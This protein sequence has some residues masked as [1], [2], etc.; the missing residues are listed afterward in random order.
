MASRV[1]Q[2][3]GPRPPSFLGQWARLK[4]RAMYTPGARP[5]TT[6]N[7]SS[8]RSLFELPRNRAATA[9]P[10]PCAMRD[11]AG[12]TARPKPSRAR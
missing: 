8:I 12:E 2:Y 3:A 10:Q 1:L 9:W 5:P 4:G 11:D 7:D 6:S